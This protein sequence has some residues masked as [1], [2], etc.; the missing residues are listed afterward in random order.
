[1]NEAGVM[2]FHDE[3]F[4]GSA[5]VLKIVQ[6][7]KNQDEKF[8]IYC[9]QDREKKLKMGEEFTKAARSIMTVARGMMVAKIVTELSL[10]NMFSTIDR[11][12]EPQR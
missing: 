5:K 11:A 3:P 8:D 10:L 12:G 7:K 4:L 1:M 2:M 6:R 9:L